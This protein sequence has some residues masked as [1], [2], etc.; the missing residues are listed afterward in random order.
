MSASGIEGATPLRVV[1]AKQTKTDAKRLRNANKGDDGDIQRTDRLRRA[2]TGKGPLHKGSWTPEEDALLEQLIRKFIDIPQPTLW[3]KVSGGKI[4]ESTLFRNRWSQL[5]P[6]PGSQTGR[7]TKQEELRLQEAISEQLGGKYQVA[8]DVLAEEYATEG[9]N[10]G[11][12]RPELQ[13]L[14]SQS[15]LPILKQGSWRLRTLSWVAIQEKVRSRDEEDCRDHFY[16]VYHNGRRG[17]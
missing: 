12:V 16:R 17:P 5:S 2:L 6:P 8:V 9:E 13:Q 7:W 11:A 14:H 1:Y 10:P 15:G 3:Y 4:G